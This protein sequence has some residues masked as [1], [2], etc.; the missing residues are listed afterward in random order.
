MIQDD[1]DLRA[2]GQGL[3]VE[4]EDADLI[5]LVKEAFHATLPLSWSEHT[6]DE[7]R[8]Y[9][10]R[11]ASGESSWEHPMD[12]VYRELVGL[13]KEARCDEAMG[14]ATMRARYIH[15]HL[16]QVHQR[17]LEALDGWSGPYV[18]TEGEYY[19]NEDLKVSVWE[20]PLTEWSHE[21]ILRHDVLC[22][23]LLPEQCM[24][25]ADGAVEPILQV[26]APRVSGAE[27]L[28]HLQLPLELVKRGDSDGSD[29]PQS[30]A[31]SRDY[32]TAR[33]GTSTTRSQLSSGDRARAAA[34][35]SSAAAAS[36]VAP[37]GAG[38]SATALAT[39]TGDVA[40]GSKRAPKPPP[41]PQ[42]VEKVTIF[43]RPVVA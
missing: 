28:Q 26:G 18:S 17:A 1:D 39:G 32:L 7:G 10:F 40:A 6:D 19:Y 38:A 43:T 5:W 16:R 21:L 22:R 8:L 41:P 42:E 13:V 4:L 20:S 30:P 14:E 33:S 27:L 34:S 25:G 9:F 36:A 37:A 23:C 3:G 12:A 29:Q 24:V 2:Y 35:A 15:A 31:T 11:E